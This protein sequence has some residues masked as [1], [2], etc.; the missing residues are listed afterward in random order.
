VNDP[1][2]RVERAFRHAIVYPSLRAIFRNRAVDL[3]IDLGSIRRLLLLR[4]DRLGDMV[5]TSSIIRRIRDRAPGVDMGMVVS[6]KNVAAAELVDGIDRLHVIGR[7]TSETLRA[8]RDARRH[9]YDVVL[10]LVFNRTTLGGVLA[11]VIAPHGVKVGQG[12][13][14]YRFYFNAMVTLERATKHMSEILESFGVQTFGP[15][16]GGTE[17]PYALHDNR[18]AA[19]RIEDRLSSLAGRPVLVNLSAGEPHRAPHPAQMIE[20][21]RA[22]LVRLPDPILVSSAPGEEGIR[23]MVVECVADP[24][25]APFPAKG[26]ASFAEMVA[27]VR[28]CRMLVTPDTSLI[29]VADATS[30][31]LLGFFSTAYSLAEWGPRHTLAE[32]V[33][34]EGDRPLSEMP[35]ARM[36]AGLECLLARMGAS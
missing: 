23:K 12:A 6:H 16:F 5:V 31:P 25:V 1:I 11:N 2:K 3:P 28:R 9:G 8:L 26:R 20:L 27:L 29:H 24:R 32:V 22:I 10:N 18:A 35:V 15:E 14:K 19:R 34:S 4:T 21:I 17:L 30:T 36:A 7:S 13:E 33:L